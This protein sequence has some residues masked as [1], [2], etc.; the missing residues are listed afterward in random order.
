MIT[1]SPH[2]YLRDGLTAGRS[3]DLVE[4][5]IHR[6]S[7][8]EAN[9]LAA[10]LT[11]K[12]L[13]HQTGADHAYL[14]NVIGR[15]IDPY[16]EFL[17]YGKRQISAPKP[18]IRFVQKWILAN[19]LNGVSCHPAS[20]AYERRKSIAQC[21]RRHL[22]ASWLVKLDVHN[23]F[24][25]IDEIQI[26][27]VFNGL[28]Y[29]RLVSFEMARLCTRPG[30][31]APHRMLAARSVSY[32]RYSKIRKYLTPVGPGFLPQGSPT[33]GALANMVMRDIDTQISEA[34]EGTGIVYTRYADDITFS[35]S[36]SFSRKEASELIQMTDTMLRRGRF[37]PHDKKTRVIPPGARKIVLGLLVDGDRIRI[38][39]D[40]RN[41]I[42]NDIRGAERFGLP[43]HARHRGFTST[44]AFGQHL[45]GMLS[46]CH[47]VDPE[48]TAPLW[49]RWT[50]LLNENLIPPKHLFQSTTDMET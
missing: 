16:S 11:L 35:T 4:L 32:D 36:G 37:L 29:G 34:I 31:G 49:G 7:A 9:G 14:R 40:R 26:L 27:H 8:T 3:R 12:H 10:V 33:S 25:S 30:V 24:A 5:F 44:I 48:W 45:A 47:D 42:I 1:D 17:L 15:D 38:P 19:I 6:A 22:G 43:V 41:R 39:V 2:I 23:F 20:F 18:P 28:G 13:A 50:T 46:Y 21:A